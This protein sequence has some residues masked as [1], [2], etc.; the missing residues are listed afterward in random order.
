MAQELKGNFPG[1]YVN[2]TKVDRSLMEYV[3]FE[4]Q[5]IGSRKVEYEIRHEGRHGAGSRFQS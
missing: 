4:N 1:P 2:D 3:P 5:D